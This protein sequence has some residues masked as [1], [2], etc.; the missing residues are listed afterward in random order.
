MEYVLVD[1]LNKEVDK[2]DLNYI[3]LQMLKYALISM[4]QIGS[5]RTIKIDLP[6]TIKIIETGSIEE[7]IN[8]F[9]QISEVEVKE[10]DKWLWFGFKN[11]IYG[12]CVLLNENAE[13]TNSVCEE[14]Y[15]FLT[16]KQIR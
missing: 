10:D 1:L 8:Y 2:V 15:V 16:Q 7:M 6:K 14:E 5:Y 3:K 12:T 4:H 9:S 13:K 11:D